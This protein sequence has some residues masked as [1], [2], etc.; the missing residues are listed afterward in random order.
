MRTVWTFWKV[1]T[2][3]GMWIFLENED[4]LSSPRVIRVK[5]WIVM[6]VVVLVTVVLGVESSS[7]SKLSFFGFSSWCFSSFIQFLSTVLILCTR[8][9]NKIKRFQ[10][11]ADVSKTKQ[12][13]RSFTDWLLLFI[14]A[15][16]QERFLFIYLECS[17]KCMT[18]GFNPQLYCFIS[19]IQWSQ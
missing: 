10:I 12:H 16:L 2:L 13:R 9:Q 8:Y 17:L 19:P 14:K 7:P 11:T 5:E 6:V 18:S 3:L 15:C 1:K 4:I